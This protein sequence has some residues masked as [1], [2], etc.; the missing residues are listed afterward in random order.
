M[1]T[2]AEDV[3]RRQLELIGEDP[4]REGL[5]ETPTRVVRSW[6]ELFAGYSMRPEDVLVKDFERDGYDEMI[7][8]RNVQFFSTCEHHLQ[9]F[10]GKAHVGYVPDER[11]I[12]ISKLARLVEVFAR[13]LQIQERLTEQIAD[14]LEKH[15]SPK[16]VAVVIEA[17]HFCMICRGIQKQTS[18]MVT[19]SLKGVFRN[20]EPRAE[21]FQLVHRSHS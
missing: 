17:Q 8:C 19:S 21:F 10:F 9:P 16:G 12:G 3:V 6:S 20:A 5:K 2:D 11:V 13:R 18:S 14:A 4:N 1:E 7:L 15:L